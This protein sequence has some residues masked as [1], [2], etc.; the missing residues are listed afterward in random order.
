MI[1]NEPDFELNV[2]DSFINEERTISLHYVI[3]MRQ[4]VIKS[5][6]F[7]PGQLFPSNNFVLTILF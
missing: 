4:I 7:D 2:L 6:Q 5:S 1:E 3:Y